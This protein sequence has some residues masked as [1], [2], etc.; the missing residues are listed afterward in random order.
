[1]K[2]TH[3]AHMLTYTPPL[4]PTCRERQKPKREE[5]EKEK[6]NGTNENHFQD[7]KIIKIPRNQS[8]RSQILLGMPTK[9]NQQYIPAKY[10]L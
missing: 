9:L 8:C 1:M 2:N 4:P 10:I 5:K 7:Q 6:G 3:A